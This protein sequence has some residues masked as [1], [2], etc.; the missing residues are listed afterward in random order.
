MIELPTS[1]KNF[2]HKLRSLGRIDH[3][4]PRAL[5][6]IGHKAPRVLIA[7]IPRCGST[8]LLR[9][10]SGHPPGSTF[11]TKCSQ[12]AFVSTLTAIPNKAF[13]K[14]H[15][16]APEILP[17]DVRTI[18]LFGDPIN[19]VWSTWNKRFNKVHFKNC[20]Y[21]QDEPP[22]ILNRDDLGYE[23]IFDSWMQPHVYPLMSIRYEKLWT[24]R[25]LLEEFIGRP[26]SLPT[27]RQR[28][29]DIP[30]ENQTQIQAAYSSLNTKVQ[31]A[32]DIAVW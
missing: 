11:P 29:T 28:S 23:S 12:C 2:R 17:A 16:K 24:Y 5:H 9:A 6:L 19:A 3:F 31:Q 22:D 4:V 26:I 21:R 32:P 18:F 7:S 10:I 1:T 8:L 13:L 15:A 27:F 20:G 30:L 14:T 25:E